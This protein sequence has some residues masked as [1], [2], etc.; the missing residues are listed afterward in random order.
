MNFS[1]QQRRLVHFKKWTHKPFGAFNSLHKT[2]KICTLA[3]AY[4][5]VAEPALVNAQ[6]TQSK[7]STAIE[8]DEV[9]VLGVPISQQV[10]ETG[11]QISVIKGRELQ[12]LPATSIEEI[13]QRVA[14]LEN[15]SRNAFGV[16]TDFSLRGSTFQQV[17]VLVDGLR[18]NDPMT[19]HFNGN[20]PV[21]PSEIEQIEIIQG[22]AAAEYGPDA[23]GGVINIITKT[24]S[25]VKQNQIFNIDTKYTIGQNNL[26]SHS[27]GV[28]SEN[29]NLKVSASVLHNQSDG[30]KIGK[31]APTRFNIN[32]YTV[33]ASYKF[34]K[35]WQLSL[36][37]AYDYRDFSAQNFYSFNASDSANEQVSR[38]WLQ[39]RIS[40]K[41]KK[42]ATRIDGGLL[43]TFD[44][45]IYNPSMLTLVPAFK[46]NMKSV[47]LNSSHLLLLNEKTELMFGLQANQRNIESNNRGNHKTWHYG[48][49]TSLKYNILENFTINT[50][51]RIDKNEIFDYNI[52]P[53]FSASFQPNKM[54]NFRIA[55]GRSVRTPDYTELYYQ[56]YGWAI[57]KTV[58]GGDK[59]GNPNLKPEDSWSY[60][61]G[62]DIFFS[63]K[64]KYSSTIF[65]RNSNNLIDY[66]LT[67]SST[68]DSMSFLK[69]QTDYL[70][71]KNIA[72]SSIIGISNEF[73][74]L[75]SFSD[76]LSFKYQINYTLQKTSNE[77]GIVTFYISNHAQQILNNQL[78]LQIGRF[79]WFIDG[80]YIVRDAHAASEIKSTNKNLKLDS[81]YFV[82]NTQLEANILPQKVWANIQVNNVF[83]KEYMAILG[84][85]M[86]KRW[87]MGGIRISI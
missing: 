77:E 63:E 14:G 87:I 26:L 43:S 61:T 31:L 35:N 44:N 71:A 42:S 13:I 72:K 52:L 64:I 66:V 65:Y 16:Q 81:E 51:L 22:P 24:F 11:R 39:T 82:C 7:D 78:N 23:V 5:M 25:Q 41:G 86:P 10:L 20:I 68:I 47:I 73:N 67:N 45:Y 30:E 6:V 28:F 34:P 74:F 70:Y 38:K 3:L 17:L 85:L 33:G 15:Q 9:V 40:H 57:G 76:K 8:I 46:N 2:V 21:A 49:F 84:P 83:D 59:V 69:Y 62:T 58:R 56:R 1:N 36:R 48:G 4:N 79:R 27:S 18:I 55:A 37:G 29:K 60:E 32:T 50:T 54:L 53:Q 19:A 80:K 12:E 75:H